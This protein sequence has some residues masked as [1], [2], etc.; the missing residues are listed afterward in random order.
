MTNEEMIKLRHDIIC[1]SNESCDGCS[2]THKGT[3]N[4]TCYN[5]LLRNADEAIGD[6]IKDYP[7]VKHI[8]FT[9]ATD[10]QKQVDHPDH[11]NREGAIECIDEMV[12]VFGVAAVRYFCLLNVWKYRFR[13]AE[14]NG[15]E[16]LKKS[17]WYMKKY[18]EL[19]GNDE[20]GLHG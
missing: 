14:K 13:A 15:A 6:Y 10:K 20:D 19:K 8:E 1:C 18:I 12:E 17:D 4:A 5:A 7:F 9:K 2:M 16:D 3:G 11:Y